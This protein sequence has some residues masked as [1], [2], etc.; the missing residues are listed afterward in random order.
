MKINFSILLILVSI[1]SFGQ[2]NFPTSIFNTKEFDFHKVEKYKIEL[3]EMELKSFKIIDTIRKPY[4]FII[5]SSSTIYIAIKNENKFNAYQLLTINENNQQEIVSKDTLKQIPKS[6]RLNTKQEDLKLIIKPIDVCVSNL[7]AGSTERISFD[8]LNNSELI[9]KFSY[10]RY[11][12]PSCSIPL[13]RQSYEGY[14][15]FDFDKLQVLDITTRSSL[16]YVSNGVDTKDRII[17]FEKNY[18]KVGKW[19]YYYKNNK[20]IRK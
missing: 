9:L 13:N 17:Q 20:L 7:Y 8:K 2:L 18:F 6:D 15:I 1:Y 11:C 3:T 14:I 19:K 10:N 16:R 12:C 5:Q 4:S